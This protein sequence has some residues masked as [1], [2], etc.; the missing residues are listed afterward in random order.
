M[1]TLQSEPIVKSIDEYAP[2]QTFEQF[3]VSKFR[4][5]LGNS[6]R[7]LCA[8]FSV[9]G[10]GEKPGIY[11][12]LTKSILGIPLNKKIEEFEKGDVHI[13]VVYTA[14][15][16]YPRAPKRYFLLHIDEWQTELYLGKVEFWTPAVSDGNLFT[17][18]PSSQKHSIGS[19]E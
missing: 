5:Y 11:R 1:R 12:M 9:R 6:I 2:G 4:P 16:K 17:P 7:E 19:S 13:R 14:R 18:P 10:R 15:P 8:K 3:V